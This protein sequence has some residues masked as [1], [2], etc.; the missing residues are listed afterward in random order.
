MIA[1]FIRA[2]LSDL[3]QQQSD[4]GFDRTLGTAIDEIYGA[5]VA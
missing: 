3:R 5:S 2:L 4:E 1:S